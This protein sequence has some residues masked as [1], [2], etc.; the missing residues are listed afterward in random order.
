MVNSPTILMIFFGKRFSDIYDSENATKS[1]EGVRSIKTYF[2]TR[3]YHF[4]DWRDK[5]IEKNAE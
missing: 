3:V 4:K 5:L 2:C 1:V